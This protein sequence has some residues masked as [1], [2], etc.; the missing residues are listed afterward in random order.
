MRVDKDD[1]G[2]EDV[3]EDAD[4]DARRGR[5]RR[6]SGG[7]GG[8]G[9]GRTTVVVVAAVVAGRARLGVG[10]G[11][12]GRGLGSKEA[13]RVAWGTPPRTNDEAP[14]RRWHDEEI[15]RERGR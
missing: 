13:W 12:T 7:G 9:G 5:R 14:V 15:T 3:D 2:D 11:E 6:E 10:V 1:D 4:E 8:G